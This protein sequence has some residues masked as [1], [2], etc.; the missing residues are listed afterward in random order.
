MASVGVVEVSLFL[1]VPSYRKINWHRFVGAKKA[2]THSDS[3]EGLMGDSVPI[4]ERRFVL[5]WNGMY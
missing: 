2:Y 5:K 4:L 1:T 3:S